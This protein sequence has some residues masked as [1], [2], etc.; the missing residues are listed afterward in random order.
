[1]TSSYGVVGSGRDEALPGEDVF[2]GGPEAVRPRLIPLLRRLDQLP[3]RSDLVVRELG[4]GLRVVLMVQGG[5]GD[6]HYMLTWYVRQWNVDRAELWSAALHNLRR[7]EVTVTLFQPDDGP[8]YQVEG[9]TFGATH[10]LRVE[11][12]I[13]VTTP[14]GYIV[15]M[16]GTNLLVVHA[17]VD[18]TSYIRIMEI[19]DMLPRLCGPNPGLSDQM[20]HWYHGRLSPVGMV[21]SQNPDGSVRHA[22]TGNA[23]FAR[24]IE[25]LTA[26]LKN[27]QHEH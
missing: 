19:R 20:F 6:L 2:A 7:K 8:V 16:P 1:M 12:L 26:K 14:N 10:L 21:D 27:K 25:E 24:V 13:G 11:E 4:G 3:D 17:L 18:A 23:D 15:A 22:M 9:A 5:E